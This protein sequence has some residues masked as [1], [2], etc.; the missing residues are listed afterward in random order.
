MP[1]EAMIHS[2]RTFDRSFRAPLERLYT[3]W[4]SA[5][6]RAVWGS[7]DPSIVIAMRAADFRVGG[8]DVSDCVMDGTVVATVRSCWLDITPQRRVVYTETISE[9]ETVQGVSLI[10]AELRAE[11]A[12]SRMVLTLQTVA[13]DGSGLEKGVVDGWTAGLESLAAFLDG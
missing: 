8:E 7:P 13:F 6:A 5:E 11:G 9:G 10:S 4:E 2:T 3:A 1:H 12:G